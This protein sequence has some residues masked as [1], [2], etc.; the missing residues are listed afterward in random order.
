MSLSAWTHHALLKGTATINFSQGRLARGA[1][2]REA[3]EVLREM[4]RAR[5]SYMEQLNRPDN[6]R[7]TVVRACDEYL[8]LLQGLLDPPAG[9]LVSGGEDAS[10]V[11]KTDS[12]EQSDKTASADAAG[13]D[14][15][16]TDA[17]TAATDGSKGG[18]KK[19]KGKKIE[20][21]KLDLVLIPGLRGATL[22]KWRDAVTGEQLDTMDAQLDK[23]CCLLNL[24]LWHC[25]HASVTSTAQR[26]E[27]GH[28]EVYVSLRE[29]AKYFHY[30]D[31]WEL[32][33]VEFRENH[34]F[35][36]RLVES[37][38]TQCLAEAQEMTLMIAKSKGHAPELIAGIAQDNA[39]KFADAKKS[40]DRMPK[41]LVGD[42]VLY[43]EFKRLF[44]EGC[45]LAYNGAVQHAKEEAGIAVKCL[46]EATRKLHEAEEV[47]NGYMRAKKRSNN[48]SFNQT[49]DNDVTKLSN[50]VELC[51]K[52]RE[53]YDTAERERGFVYHQSI[54]D[55]LPE[56]LVPAKNLVGGFAEYQLPPLSEMWSKAQFNEGLI[57]LKGKDTAA[58]TA[59]GDN[60][61]IREGRHVAARKRDESCVV[62]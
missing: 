5:S 16:T 22:F 44:Y 62:M 50:W 47:A 58:D 25:L 37:M 56:D 54:P 10:S 14:A 49:K 34:D 61:T 60:A 2:N 21:A 26:D 42:L 27:A 20:E 29:A 52:V 35:D 38:A 28:K 9:S 59:S 32:E 23:V 39:E 3:R 13:G 24:G 53:I 51:K 4:T 19:K 7:E 46:Q 15:P 8:A 18:N 36:E 57:P 33:R 12:G 6:S 55:E 31:K 40:I 11:S 1:V 30:V 43:C 45:A 48:K 41:N 17:D